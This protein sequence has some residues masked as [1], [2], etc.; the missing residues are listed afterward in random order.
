MELSG[1]FARRVRK[2]SFLNLE[3]VSQ[4]GVEPAT[5]RLG[6]ICS[7]SSFL[8]SQAYFE[9][10]YLVFASELY[11]L[12]SPCLWQIYGTGRSFH[13]EFFQTFARL[14]IAMAFP[15]VRNS[16]REYKKLWN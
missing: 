11:Q 15:I 14:S 1:T 7:F 3:I 16:L 9:R 5:Y 4:T 2:E 10:K 13:A 6:G 8:D 12:V